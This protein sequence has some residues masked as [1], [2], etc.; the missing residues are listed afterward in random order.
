[1]RDLTTRFEAFSPL[2]TWLIDLL[3]HFAIMNNPSRQALPINSAFR[4]VFQ[5]LASGLFLPGSS[6]IS[7]PCE[8]GHIRVHTILT[9]EQQD[10]LCMSAQTI[11]RILMHGGYKVE[12]LYLQGE[13]YV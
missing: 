13:V 7:D 2:N 1:M 3:A 10:N 6:G 11:L 8:V 5:L 12:L 4:R 9:L